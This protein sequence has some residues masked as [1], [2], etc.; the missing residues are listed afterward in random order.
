MM[1]CLRHTRSIN[2]SSDSGSS[3]PARV[4]LS[5][6]RSKYAYEQQWHGLPADEIEEVDDASINLSHHNSSEVNSQFMSVS[7][8]SVSEVC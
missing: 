1:L 3:G 4:P 8:V 7:E 6:A 2:L 5:V